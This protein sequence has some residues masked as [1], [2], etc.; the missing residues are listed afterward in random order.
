MTPR[1]FATGCSV[2]FVLFVV[3]CCAGVTLYYFNV[4]KG[5]AVA[6]TNAACIINGTV[7]V[8][9]LPDLSPLTK[10]EESNAATIV[11]VGQAMS[12]PP[13]G[14]IVAVA[15]AMQESHLQNLKNL[16]ARNDH[17]S[18]GLFQQ[19]PS[20][21]WGTPAQIL[22]PTYASTKFYTKLLTI[23]GWQTLPLT[24]AAQDVQ[25]SAYPDAYAKWEP[26]ATQ[27]V[28]ALVAGSP[29][30]PSAAPGQACSVDGGDLKLDSGAVSLPA[31]FSLPAG[32]PTAVV[33]AINWALSQIGTP[34]SFGGSC[35]D[36]HSG[37]RAKEC[38]CS[39]L[40][41]MSYR[42]GGVT[43]PRLAAEQSRVGTPIYDLRT[44][45]PG[46]LLFLVGSD[47]T[48]DNPGHV[49]MYLGQG[50]I[51]NAPHTGTV[52]RLATLADW[53]NGI[54]AARRIVQPQV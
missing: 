14:W 26:D 51:I 44:L 35:T 52:V 46:D 12:V 7:A 23:K 32:T 40:T 53:S 19:R 5:P 27:L 45:Q 24:V 50:V 42:A 48:R 3:C 21:G 31:G 8:A 36:A 29:G 16:G 4:K 34:Y 20:Q 1:R 10:P 13:R 39:S 15:T 11:T 47:G 6:G 38:D 9:D 25:H 18:L 33:T 2:L 43:I 17:D 28:G 30:S 22:D 37:N 54:V 49:G 41:M